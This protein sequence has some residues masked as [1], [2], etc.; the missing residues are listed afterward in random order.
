MGD[1]SRLVL[2][3][4]HD[5]EAM[6]TESS[7]QMMSHQGV[8]TQVMCLTTMPIIK[9]S[10]V[11]MNTLTGQKTPVTPTRVWKMPCT[12]SRPIKSDVQIMRNA[13]AAAMRR[14]AAKKQSGAKTSDV[15]AKPIS[16]RKRGVSKSTLEMEASRQYNV[17]RKH[18]VRGCCAYWNY[19]Y[20]A[21]FVL[22]AGDPVKRFFVH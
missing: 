16:K 15:A 8:Y 2:L 4:T 9:T 3:L 14:L 22:P 21:Q 19:Y 17:Y 1:P 11:L 13:Y 10:A 12:A 5:V 20:D 6:T 18:N 7:Q